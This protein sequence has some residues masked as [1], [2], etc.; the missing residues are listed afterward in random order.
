M[1]STVGSGKTG[2]VS[3]NFFIETL[4]SLGQPLDEGY[5]SSNWDFNEVDAP[6]QRSDEANA[7]GGEEWQLH[8]LRTT[9]YARTDHERERNAEGPSGVIGPEMLFP[10][11]RSTESID[12]SGISISPA[13]YD[14]PDGPMLFEEWKRLYQEHV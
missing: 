11:T 3:S 2:E 6:F 4:L 8:P 7:E 10:P 13:L 9:S 5:S 14:G 1:H 12:S